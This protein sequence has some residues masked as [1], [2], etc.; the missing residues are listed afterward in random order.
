[1]KILSFFLLFSQ[2]NAVSN[3]LNTKVWEDLAERV[4]TLIAL[5]VLMIHAEAAG[6]SARLRY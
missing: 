3:D 1:M 5:M 4:L 2:I 6:R